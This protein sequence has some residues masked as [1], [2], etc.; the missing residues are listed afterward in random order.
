VSENQ[1][2]SLVYDSECGKVS[3]VS[4]RGFE[5]YAELFS[6]SGTVS[7]CREES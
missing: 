4:A 2:T 5:D 7:F 6:E 1:H 3:G